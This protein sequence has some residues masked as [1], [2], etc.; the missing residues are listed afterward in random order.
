M[1]AYGCACARVCVRVLVRVRVCGCV[2]EGEGVQK[3][4]IIHYINLGIY[5]GFWSCLSALTNLT[6][7]YVGG[8][9]ARWLGSWVYNVFTF[10]R[11]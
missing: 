1:R 7:Y 5:L 4:I 6:S 9:L 2:C 11:F 3:I 10:S 8:S